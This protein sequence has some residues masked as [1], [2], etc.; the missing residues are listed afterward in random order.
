V[1]IQRLPKGIRAGTGKKL[2]PSDSQPAGED[3]L[4]GVD[5][6]GKRLFDRLATRVNRFGDRRWNV[7][8]LIVR[9]QLVSKGVFHAFQQVP[10]LVIG[11][12]AAGPNDKQHVGT[13]I[14]RC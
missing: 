1:S 8:L 4:K 6:F 5:A 7:E 2:A 12:G 9:Q 13:R 14:T 11:G 10:R 3:V